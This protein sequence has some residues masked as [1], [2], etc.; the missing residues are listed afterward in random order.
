[1]KIKSEIDHCNLEKDALDKAK[2]KEIQ[3]LCKRYN[4]AKLLS[5]TKTT[6]DH[7]ISQ[8]LRDILSEQQQICDKLKYYEVQLGTIKE[9]IA[10]SMHS[11]M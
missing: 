10:Y 3:W 11:T 1:M 6:K 7:R 8:K 5:L 4:N 9:E 2:K